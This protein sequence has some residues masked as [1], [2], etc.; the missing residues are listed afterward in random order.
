MMLKAVSDVRLEHMITKRAL[1][2]DKYPLMYK[3]WGRP[4]GEG[5]M[6][7]LPDLLLSDKNPI[8]AMIIE[9]TNP[10]MTWPDSTK[11]AKALKKVEFL[12]Y[13]GQ[14]MTSSADLADIFLPTQG[15]LEKSDFCIDNRITPYIMMKKPI[16]QIGEC[17]HDATFWLQLAKRMGYD[18][19]FPWNNS[20]EF[21]D[22]WLEPSEV[23]FKMLTEEKPGGMHL[24]MK[25]GTLRKN[26]FP[27]PSGKVEIW[28]E[29]ME[30]FG[31]DPLPTYKE[32]YESPASRPDLA[33]EYPLILTTG[34]RNINFLHSQMRNVPTLRARWPEPLADVHPETA[35]RY[36]ISDG[37]MITISTR[38]GSI[39]IKA[40]LTEDNFPGLVSVP[41]GWVE[42]NVN[43]LTFARP[44]DPVTGVPNMKALLCRIEKKKS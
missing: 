7:D 26:G 17:W 34:Q 12:V 2:E 27:T 24:E 33:K 18:E 31:Y 39:D 22:Y 1:F 29:T 14:Y 35:K 16:V 4:M 37:D 44:A 10:L 13:M 8:K 43:V 5:Q 25:Y 38:R 6:M 28:S 32:P 30:Q 40:H 23:S 3:L 42:A 11:V 15:P 41:H 21:I 20:D 9:C 19:Y 36:G